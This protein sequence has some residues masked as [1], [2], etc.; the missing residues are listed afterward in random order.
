MSPWPPSKP[1]NAASGRKR[2]AGMVGKK[3]RRPHPVDRLTVD[4]IWRRCR[5]PGRYADG[6]GLYLF[7]DDTGGKRWIWRGIVNGKRCDLGL[8]N[9]Q[10]ITLADARALAIEYRRAA[11]RGAVPGPSTIEVPMANSALMK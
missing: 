3:P 7:V 9:I 1:S 6:N 4:D 5:R 8:G 2:P 10:L 11:R